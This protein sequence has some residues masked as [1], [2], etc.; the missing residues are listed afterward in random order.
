MKRILII[1]CPGAGKTTL[2]K[3]LAHAEA[4]PIVHLDH[5]WWKP[6]WQERSE[7]EFDANLLSALQKDRWIMDGNYARTL[8]RRLEYADTVIL[9]DFNRW[10]CAYRALKRW[11][12]GEGEQAKGCPQ[13]VDL[14]FLKFILWDYPVGQRLQIL[15]KLKNTSINVVHLKNPAAL[16][17]WEKQR[18]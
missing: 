5:L 10:T 9:L 4:L 17:E 13:K 1:G 3:T 14:P 8:A 12:K 7:A 6:G 16:E 18:I 11:W 2:S 15:E